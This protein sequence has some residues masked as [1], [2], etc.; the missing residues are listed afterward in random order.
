MVWR[1][2]SEMSKQQNPKANPLN[3]LAATNLKLAEQTPDQM[4]KSH[5]R[6]MAAKLTE[7]AT[8]K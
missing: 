2:E 3:A 1:V 8:S 7:A 4:E 5:R 6:K